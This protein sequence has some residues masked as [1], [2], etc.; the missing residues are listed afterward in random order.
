[1]VFS[2]VPKF[3]PQDQL[4]SVKSVISLIRYHVKVRHKDREITLKDVTKH[5]YCKWFADT[6]FC[7]SELTVQRRLTQ[8]YNTFH[9][10]RKRISEKGNE[11]SVAVKGY[12]KTF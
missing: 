12:K 3:Q 1:M 4:P 9:E 10:G 2:P 11:N 7:V 5:I 8:I 6:V